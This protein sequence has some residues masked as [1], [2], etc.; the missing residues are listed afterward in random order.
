MQKDKLKIG[1]KKKFD[2]LKNRSLIYLFC[3][4]MM[5]GFTLDVI[6]VEFPTP[7]YYLNFAN[8]LISVVVL[9]LFYFNNIEI[10]N[11]VKVNII[12]LL[13]NLLLSFIFNPPD[14]IDYTGMF[15]RNAFIMFMFIPVYG[16]YCGKNSIFHIGIV[17][18][19]LFVAVLFR[20]NNHF[21]VN[22]APILIFGTAIYHLT[23]YY[24][25]DALER[26]QKS[27]IELNESLESQ[28]DQ[29]VL[30]NKDLEQKNQQIVD[31][32]KELS[33]SLSTKDKLFSI[34]AH[35]LR[36]PFNSII[37]FSDLLVNNIEA[38]AWHFR[39]R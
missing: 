16:L 19:I 2:P 35:D 30:K 12:G 4:I 27:Q 24:I 29:L 23:F 5:T 1:A 13:A 22:N 32:A 11:V 28:K 7:V 21:L 37:G 20:A 3:G 6:F 25:F 10:K 15:L 31:Q 33:Q 9:I 36:S 8:I 18:F 38:Y 34:I 39:T 26:M 17:F 14:A